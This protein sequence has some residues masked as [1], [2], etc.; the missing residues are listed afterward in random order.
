MCINA[1]T[2]E[3]VIQAV[4]LSSIDSFIHPSNLFYR[5]KKSNS[6]VQSTSPIV[7]TAIGSD[8]T[9]IQEEGEPVDSPIS[10]IP[11]DTESYEYIWRIDL[12]NTEQ[13]WEGW[14]K[15]LSKVLFTTSVP[16]M[17]ILAGK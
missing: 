15:G 3:K 6:S 16:K 10:S 2:I 13:Y 17:L 1:R 9:S 7:A 11:S 5:I 8:V 12:S 14:F 4:C